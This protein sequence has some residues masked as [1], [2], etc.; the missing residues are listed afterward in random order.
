MSYSKYLFFYYKEIYC[1]KNQKS[2]LVRNLCQG[3]TITVKKDLQDQDKLGGNI[4]AF[5]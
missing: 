4:L 1:Y 2:Q 3:A 5:K